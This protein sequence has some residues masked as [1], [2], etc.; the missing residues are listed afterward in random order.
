MGAVATA[1]AGIVLSFLVLFLSPLVPGVPPRLGT[2]IATA[3][4]TAATFLALLGIARIG[5]GNGLALAGALLCGGGWWALGGLKAEGM[6]RLVVS[7][8]A[9]VLFMLACALLG[10]LLAGLVRERNLLLPVLIVA[11]V[12]D[13]FT[14]AAGPT[15]K[16]LERAPKV[17]RSLGLQVPRA[18]SA[19]GEKG[20]AGLAAAAS[21]GLGDFI[22]AALFLTAA[23]RHGLNVRAAAVLAAMLCIA[24]MSAVLLLPSLPAVPLLPF[25]AL[26]MLLPN[27]RFFQLSAE[28]K[29]ALAA[30]AVFLVLILG[31]FYILTR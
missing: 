26:G 27:A 4:L 10:T 23:Y 2:A 12:A 11:A 1:A 29:R 16:A 5:L 15:R 20:L 7:S 14:V 9:G 17:V 3:L 28:E 24:A 22:F 19:A 18:G 13:I 30:G 8:C 6:A 25:I 21:I 31:A